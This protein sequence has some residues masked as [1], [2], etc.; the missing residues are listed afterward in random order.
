[1]RAAQLFA[2]AAHAAGGGTPQPT[3]DLLPDSASVVVGTVAA[4]GAGSLA[5]ALTDDSD[6]SYA[7]FTGGDGKGLP[8]QI[9]FTFADLVGAAGRD[10]ASF[11]YIVRC[12]VTSTGAGRV[13]VNAHATGATVTPGFAN[14]NGNTS[15]TDITLGPFTKSGG[16]NFTQ[17][18]INAADGVLQLGTDVSAQGKAYKIICRVTYA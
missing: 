4:V 8:G 18:Q 2:M 1:M 15:P 17:A 13:N 5:A 11:V 16:G 7:N 12:S 10:I 6:S 14:N 3:E 9:I